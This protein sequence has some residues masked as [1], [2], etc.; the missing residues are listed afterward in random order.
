VGDNTAA[1]QIVVDHGGVD[2]ILPAKIKAF[3]KNKF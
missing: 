1:R 3:I 2:P